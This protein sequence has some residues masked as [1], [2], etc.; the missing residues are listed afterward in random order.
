MVADRL[1]GAAWAAF[2]MVMQWTDAP[3]L[4]VEDAPANCPEGHL[5]IWIREPT[6]L[7]NLDPGKCLLI[8]VLQMIL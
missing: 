3:G 7:R 5:G 4:D 8:F 6:N 2:G 1:G